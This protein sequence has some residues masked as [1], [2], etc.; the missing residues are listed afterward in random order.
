MTE[1]PELLEKRYPFG[2][3]HPDREGAELKIVF[4]KGEWIHV[5]VE[6]YYKVCTGYKSAH[7]DEKTCTPWKRI[8]VQ[9]AGFTDSADEVDG[10]SAF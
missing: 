3:S 9:E 7:S 6:Y 8:H 4:H 5:Q 10:V 1:L 2:G